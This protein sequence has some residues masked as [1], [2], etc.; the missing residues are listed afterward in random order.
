[1]PKRFSEVNWDD[2]KYFLAVAQE[3]TVRSAA[4]LLRTNHATVSRRLT[5]LES[6]LGARLFDRSREGLKLTQ[7]GEEMR[8]YAENVAEEIASAS[9]TVAGRDHKPSGPIYVTLPPFLFSSSIGTD[10]AAFGQEYGDID[11]HLDV[12]NSLAD[13]DRREADISIRYVHEVTDDVVG[14]V[15]VNC[16][17]AAYCSPE[18][19]KQIKD[20]RG[21]GL[22]FI[23]W[24]EPE[25][26]KTAKWIKETDYPEATLRHRAMEGWPHIVFARAGVGL[27]L[28]P[29]F[30]G[31]WTDGLVRAPYQSPTPDR[32]LWVLMH[33][34]LRKNAK[35]RV[36]V[37]FLTNR[38]RSR[39]DEF[40]VPE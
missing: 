15:L 27:T 36:F 5:S 3:G 17:R 37:D 25:S 22:H 4:E 8:P 30:V 1:M 26:A 38:I 33:R 20:N 2:L 29:A 21:R 18:Y 39:R 7:L 13:L 31:D 23:G 16:K 11:I 40:E 24:D 19:A 12:S 9:R 10:L 28:I 34:D 32:K 14:R 6:S 35:I